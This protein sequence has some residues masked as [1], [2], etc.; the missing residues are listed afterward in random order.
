MLYNLPHNEKIFV[1]GTKIL[2]QQN[3]KFDKKYSACS[4]LKKGKTIE[5]RMLYS[6]TVPSC[7][8]V[9]HSRQLLS[10]TLLASLL[11]TQ[12]TTVQTVN[13]TSQNV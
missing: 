6:P 13:F 9:L 12:V 3:Q 4:S 1:H 11:T 10:A 2:H 7:V 8:A 5:V